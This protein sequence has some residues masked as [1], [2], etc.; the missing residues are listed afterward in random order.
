MPILEKLFEHNNWANRTIIRACASLFDD[1][2]D[3]RPQSDKHWSIRENLVHLVEAQQD[4]FLMVTRPTEART[5]PA[6]AFEELEAAA[7]ASGAGLLDAAKGDPT[8]AL[9]LPEG[10][11]IEPWVVLAQALNH[12]AE[13]RKQVAFLM[14]AQGLEPPRLDGWAFGEASGALASTRE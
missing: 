9:E 12:G 4:Y 8:V 11:R 10:Y 14:R 3:A 2:L 7:D 1:Q 5:N 6:P 13:H